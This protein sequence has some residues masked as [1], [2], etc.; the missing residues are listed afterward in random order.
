MELVRLIVD[1]FPYLD[2][3][4]YVRELN[5]RLSGQALGHEGRGGPLQVSFFCF[6]ED[7]SIDFGGAYHPLYSEEGDSQGIAEWFYG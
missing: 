2:E 1:G 5:R 7:G 3:T 6:R 4:E